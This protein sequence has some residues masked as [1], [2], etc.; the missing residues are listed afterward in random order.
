MHFICLGKYLPNNQIYSFQAKG[1][2]VHLI[3]G[4]VFDVKYS[5]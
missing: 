4:S 5:G 2:T 1:V 3:V